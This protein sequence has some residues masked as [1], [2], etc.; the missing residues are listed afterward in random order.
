VTP[1]RFYI[2]LLQP[3]LFLLFQWV[4]EDMKISRPDIHLLHKRPAQVVPPC[5]FQKPSQKIEFGPTRQPRNRAML[6]YHFV[7]KDPNSARTDGK[8]IVSAERSFCLLRLLSFLRAEQSPSDLCPLPSYR[9]PT[10]WQRRELPCFCFLFSIP[11]R[12]Q[13]P[14]ADSSLAQFWRPQ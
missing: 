1:G 4:S 10:S 9:L 8:I 3:D 5:T 2:N 6:Q 13:R 14:V 12:A 11:F 7:C